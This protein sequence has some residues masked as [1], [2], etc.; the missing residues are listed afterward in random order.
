MPGAETGVLHRQTTLQLAT[1]S[2]HTPTASQGRTHV[3]AAGADAAYHAAGLRLDAVGQHLPAHLQRG[4][5]LEGAELRAGGKRQHL[6]L[7]VSD[8]TSRLR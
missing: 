4:H 3:V 8:S 1:D 6:M 7:L 2:V 5:A